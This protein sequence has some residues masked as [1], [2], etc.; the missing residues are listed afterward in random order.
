MRA[1]PTAP[2]TLKR[3]YKEASAIVFLHTNKDAIYE[4][5]ENQDTTQAQRVLA[6]LRELLAE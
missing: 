5:L 3:E 6:G 2:A 1:N 4:A